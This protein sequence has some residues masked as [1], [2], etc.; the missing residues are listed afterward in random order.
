VTAATAI[1]LAGVL[2]ASTGQ[3]LMKKGALRSGSRSLTRSFLDPYLIAG[4]LLMLVSTITATIALKVLPLRVT[5]SLL[6]LGYLNVV[7]LS[8]TVLR[9]K[10]KRHHVLGMLII[11]IGIVVFHLGTVP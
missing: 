6:P 4:Y 7:L 8:V 3:I 10:M 11:L 9:E 2:V 5:V 1:F